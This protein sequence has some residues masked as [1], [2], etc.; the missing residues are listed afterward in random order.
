[1]PEALI[2]EARHPES[3]DEMLDRGWI[4]GGLVL[5]PAIGRETWIVGKEYVRFSSCFNI[6]TELR[7]GCRQYFAG[8]GPIC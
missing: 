7:Q 5:S 8:T 2:R 3:I 1:M 4:L 6:S